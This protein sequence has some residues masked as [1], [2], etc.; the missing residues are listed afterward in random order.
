LRGLVRGCPEL[1]QHHRTSDSG[2]F[3]GVNTE[4]DY[5]RLLRLGAGGR[6]IS[7]P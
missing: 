6:P 2:A 7:A 1:V 5:R 3:A 4:E